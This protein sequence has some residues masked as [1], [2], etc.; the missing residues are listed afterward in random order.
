MKIPERIKNSTDW[1]MH[2]N[3]YLSFKNPL[4]WPICIILATMFSVFSVGVV[5]LLIL[6]S[7]GGLGHLDSVEKIFD[8]LRYIWPVYLIAVPIPIIVLSGV[9]RSTFKTS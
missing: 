6:I 2:D 8:F 5:T 1:L 4:P 7:K 9:I 3:S